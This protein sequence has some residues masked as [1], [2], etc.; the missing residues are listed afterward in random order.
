MKTGY[1]FFLIVLIVAFL[2][3]F[4]LYA[5]TNNQENA[6]DFNQNKTDFNLNQENNSNTDSNNSAN[7]N[8]GLIDKDQQTVKEIDPLIEE[9][10]KI[11]LA[12]LLVKTPTFA[13]DGLKDTITLVGYQKMGE[14]Q[15]VY[16]FRYYCTHPGYGDRTGAPIPEEKTDHA[17]L[18][19]VTDK[20]V[21]FAGTDNKYDEITK[22]YMLFNPEIK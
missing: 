10:A 8:Q 16:K 17:T 9:Y 20:N 7:E 14:K 15:I 6:S 3:V 5:Y 2:V 19:M 18:I 1:S 13:Y 11:A 21:T 4:V 12:Y 22:S